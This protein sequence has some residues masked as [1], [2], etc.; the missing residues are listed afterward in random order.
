MGCKLIVG[1]ANE[2]QAREV[3]GF[4]GERHAL[5]SVFVPIAMSL[6]AGR[7][8]VLVRKPMAR[9]RAGHQGLAAGVREELLVR[10]GHTVASDY[11]RERMGFSGNVVETTKGFPI[12]DGKM[13]E[14]VG[15]ANV[16]GDN[17]GNL[18]LKLIVIFVL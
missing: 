2:R 3:R 16:F 17:S 11:V 1:Q 6:P 5:L 14:R 12:S 18:I 13:D 4:G 15:C 8:A 7:C 10:R 9:Q